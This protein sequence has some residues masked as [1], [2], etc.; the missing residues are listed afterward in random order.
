MVFD[1][2]ELHTTSSVCQKRKTICTSMR[3]NV[4]GPKMRSMCDERRRA[5]KNRLREAL[6]WKSSMRPGKPAAR[7]PDIKAAWRG[8]KRRGTN[9]WLPEMVL[10]YPK[11]VLCRLW[12][13][14]TQKWRRGHPKIL[15]NPISAKSCAKEN[16]SFCFA[17][18]EPFLFFRHLVIRLREIWV[19]SMGQWHFH[20]FWH[21]GFWHSE[22]T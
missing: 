6:C 13:C 21:L 3:H 17:E 9:N 8:G 1:L 16:N 7:R 22:K 5:G 15:L 18:K 10:C 20:K 4:P 14:A 2:N 11:T 19:C 12:N